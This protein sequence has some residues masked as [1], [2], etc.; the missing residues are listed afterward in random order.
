M[1]RLVQAD[2]G[3]NREDQHGVEREQPEG[4]CPH[5]L[6]PAEARLGHGMACAGDDA[7]RHQPD[8]LRSPYQEQPD[9][10]EAHDQHRRADRHPAAA[11]AAVAHGELRD[12]RQGHE[13]QHLRQGGD[14]GG[15]R[16]AR[17]E[18]VVQRAVQAEI[19]RPRP[20]H[21]REAEQ[22]IEHHERLRERQRHARKPRAQHGEAEDEPRA[23]AIEERSQHR[24]DDRRQHAAQRHRARHLGAR[25]AERVGHRHDE[26]RQHGHRRPLPREAGQ[27]DAAQHDPAVEERQA[28]DEQ[29]WQER[30]LHR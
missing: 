15:Q 20:G 8:I 6:G 28:R 26:D 25:P 22:Q 14:R 30:W 29:A 17:H 27:A 7:V 2:A 3:L 1:R 10:H 12:D 9:R 5:R 13:P 21:A 23:P 18:P 24:R 4:P 19:E 16:A 11:P